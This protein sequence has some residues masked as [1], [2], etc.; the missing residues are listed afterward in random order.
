M[1][2]GFMIAPCRSMKSKTSLSISRSGL[3]W[4]ELADKPFKWS[5]VLKDATEAEE[6]QAEVGKATK[7]EQQLS[8]L[9]A[10]L[11]EYFLTYDAPQPIKQSYADL[12]SLKTRKAELEESI[13][14]TMV[15]K[16][17]K[18]PR[19]TFVLGRGDYRN[20]GDKVSPNVPSCLPPFSKGCPS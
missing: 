1:I 11:S 5:N 8:E 2:C 9:R 14:T 4:R 13:P 3:S 12:K 16:E 20:H 10:K 19:E 17:M 6:E 7:E 18:K 15:M